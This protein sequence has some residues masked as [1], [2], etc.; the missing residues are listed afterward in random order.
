MPSPCSEEQ[1][2]TML[3]MMLQFRIVQLPL[4]SLH[5]Q[6][7]S[8]HQSADTTSTLLGGVV[9]D[10]AVRENRRGVGNTHATPVSPFDGGVVEE[11]AG[12]R[13]AK[14]DSFPAIGG[15]GC[16]DDRGTCG[17]AHL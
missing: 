14:Q 12:R 13:I 4:T 5:D 17:A 11:G 8:S 10:D 7:V 6:G 16:E 9:S 15:T 2:L 1:P 3:P